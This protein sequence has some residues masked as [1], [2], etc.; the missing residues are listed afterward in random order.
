MLKK[1]IN[2]FERANKVLIIFH[3]SP[4]GDAIASS[5]ALGRILEK[6]GKKVDFA[7]RDE[8]PEIFYFIPEIDRVN[9]DFILGDYDLVCV[10]D[11]GDARRTGFPE[12]LREFSKKQKK[13]VNIDHHLKNDLHKIANLNFVDD[14]AAASAELIYRIISEMGIAIDKYLSTLLLTGLY[15]DTGG[16]QHSNTS[17]Q[18]YGLASK[19][20]A[21]GA[22][23]NKI[24]KNIA[25]NRKLATLKLWGLAMARVYKNRWGMAISYIKQDDLK[26]L[27]ATLDDAAGIVNVINSIPDANI[28]ILFTELPEGKIKAS[29]RT[30][31]SDI[32]VSVFANYF[33]G[34]GH[35]KASGFSLDGEI[36]QLSETC[37][38]VDQKAQ[39]C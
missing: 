22:S 15:T 28:A 30:E 29:V 1:L 13:L 12:R 25:L 3:E 27:C 20:L 39:I 24:S 21:N 23:L 37:W 7:C 18:V 32:D 31:S 11:C 14:K 36:R 34:G 10:I 38:T 35:K 26:K 8:I 19:L 2:W 4:D 17:P 33:G 5:L 16:F 6:I 9:K